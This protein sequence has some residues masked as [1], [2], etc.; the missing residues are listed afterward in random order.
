VVKVKQKPASIFLYIGGL[1]CATYALPTITP[2]HCHSGH[3]SQECV[4]LSSGDSFGLSVILDYKNQTGFIM[5][6]R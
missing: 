4:F 2:A 5:V 3:I 6:M 1:R